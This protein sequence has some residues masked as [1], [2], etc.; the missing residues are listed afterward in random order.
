MSASPQELEA[1]IKAL[2]AIS[3][4]TQRGKG[5]I[6]AQA[7]IESQISSLKAEIEALQ[8][9]ADEKVKLHEEA[10]VGAKSEA[11]IA[12]MVAGAVS[13]GLVGATLAWSPI[14]IEP[15]PLL[16]F[17]PQ[18]FRTA[19]DLTPG[20]DNWRARR[21]GFTTE[22]LQAERRL[23]AIELKATLHGNRLLRLEKFSNKAARGLTSAHRRSA[24][25]DTRTGGLESGATGA[26][27]SIQRL[28]TDVDR[29][30]ARIG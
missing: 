23:E 21:S 5:D 24:Q 7:S 20:Y 4:T 16:R 10:G 25:L 30:A 17:E 2:E 28:R 11:V 12:A 26:A 14:K 3:P 22:S 29:L 1:R 6:T 8:K 15:K 27:Q 18:M 9:D 19:K 13:A